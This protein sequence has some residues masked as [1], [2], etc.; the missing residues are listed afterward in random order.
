MVPSRLLAHI[1][2][3][4]WRAAHQVHKE[5]LRDNPSRSADAASVPSLATL[6]RRIIMVKNLAI[7]NSV[8][9]ELLKSPPGM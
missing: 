4:D 9:A 3:S 6:M 8:Q 1:R 7:A 2:D 5:W